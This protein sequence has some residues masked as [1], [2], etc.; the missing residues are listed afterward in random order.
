VVKVTGLALVVVA[1]ASPRWHDHAAGLDPHDDLP[2]VVLAIVAMLAC[3]VTMFVHAWGSAIVAYSTCLVA[4]LVG[5][6]WPHG[7][8]GG[9][10]ELLLVVGFALAL[11]G[12]ANTPVDGKRDRAK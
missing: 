11:V 2:L 7:D 12:I 8:R 9:S 3:G 4:L 6:F 1:L 10:P 5:Y